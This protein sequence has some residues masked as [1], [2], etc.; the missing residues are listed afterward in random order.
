M[1]VTS[2]VTIQTTGAQFQQTHE[3]CRLRGRQDELRDGGGQALQ[4]S[5]RLLSAERVKS[6]RNNFYYRSNTREK[7]PS[8]NSSYH[9]S[10][11]LFTF[12]YKLP[13]LFAA[14]HFLSIKSARN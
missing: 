8:A 7:S 1:L 9:G 11:L 6:G 14:D 2:I 12:S 4:V 10:S 3:P 13:K 5:G